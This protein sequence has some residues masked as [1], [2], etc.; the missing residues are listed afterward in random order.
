[1][2]SNPSPSDASNMAVRFLLRKA[3]AVHL[4]SMYDHTSS[5]GKEAWEDI[6]SNVFSGR[7]AYCGRVGQQLQV[8]HLHMINRT[9]LGIHHPGNTVPSCKGCNKRTRLA[10]NQ[11]ADWEKHLESICAERNETDKFEERRIRIANHMQEGDYK[12]PWTSDSAQN[13]VRMITDE[14]YNDIS[15]ECRKALRRYERLLRTFVDN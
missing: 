11:F 10:G 1:M 15:E 4:D 8:E 12:L 9:Q 6:V 2:P 5:W 14:L 7:C 3:G 13:A